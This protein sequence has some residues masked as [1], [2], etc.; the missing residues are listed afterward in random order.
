MQNNFE[1]KHIKNAKKS[2]S[3]ELNSARQDLNN[4]NAMQ[5]ELLNERL[6]QL[7]EERSL[8]HKIRTFF[9]K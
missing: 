3:Q 8:W 7:L 9:N 5:E 4:Y 6:K 2:L 1:A